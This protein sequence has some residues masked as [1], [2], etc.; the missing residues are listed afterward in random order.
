[1]TGRSK[2]SSSDDDGDVLLFGRAVLFWLIF[3]RT[4]VR[5][6]AMDTQLLKTVGQI[7]GVAGLGI[8]AVV[9]VFQEVL[10]KIIFPKLSPAEAFRILR[11]IVVL[12][13]SVG[14]LGIMAW[15]YVGIPDKNHV[16]DTKQV[17]SGP[18]SPAIAHVNGDVNFNSSGGDGRS[19]K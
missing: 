4:V 8:G 6:I 19:S 10:R 12:T 7:G 9:L 18:E 16:G 14:A 17:T 1:V 2:V 15:A 3:G 13:W 5:D 11:L